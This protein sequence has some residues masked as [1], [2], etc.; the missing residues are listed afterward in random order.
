MSWYRGAITLP[1]DG[2]REFLAK[3]D[4][5]GMYDQI[6]RAERGSR[7]VEVEAGPLSRRA[8]DTISSC[9]ATT[10]ALR[11]MPFESIR[12]APPV[13][14]RHVRG[15]T[16]PDGASVAASEAVASVESAGA[17]RI[18]GAQVEPGNDTAP[19]AVE[20]PDD[21]PDPPP[22]LEILLPGIDLRSLEIP[23]ERSTRPTPDPKGVERA[24]L[25]IA[26]VESTGPDDYRLPALDAY[27]RAVFGYGLV[28]GMKKLQAKEPGIVERL[29]AQER[30]AQAAAAD[31][32]SA[33]R[34]GEPER[35]IT[36]TELRAAAAAQ[37]D[38][39]GSPGHPDG[40]A[41]PPSQTSVEAGT[42]NSVDTSKRRQARAKLL[43]LP[44]G[45]VSNRKRAAQSA[46]GK[47]GRGRHTTKGKEASSV[48]AAR[49]YQQ[50]DREVVPAGPFREDADEVKQYIRQTVIGYAPINWA[51]HHIAV[52]MARSM[53]SYRRG[54]IAETLS[55]TA[56]SSEYGGGPELQ[57]AT[58]AEVK[59]ATARAI[60]DWVQRARAA[61]DKSGRHDW[62]RIVEPT[63]E[64]DEAEAFVLLLRE[65]FGNLDAGDPTLPEY[66]P[67]TQRQWANLVKSYI[68]E[69]L[70]DEWEQVEIFAESKIRNLEN[71]AAA[72]RTKSRADR[73]LIDARNLEQNMPM[74]SK[75][76]DLQA[77]ITRKLNGLQAAFDKAQAAGPDADYPGPQNVE[78]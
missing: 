9:Q 10:Q 72:Y 4:P 50:S 77:R 37:L 19:A 75:V 40:T 15:A 3:Q 65:Y 66:R 74:I 52:Q 56:V 60:R 76:A 28:A 24:L 26:L 22:W 41:T 35:I 62:R 36:G 34:D 53:Q 1:G 8:A 47:K 6:L 20:V 25:E 48:N 61:I 11:D 23:G 64:R 59:A 43:R 12:P 67:T 44:P 18:E 63:F 54:D 21:K 33:R 78:Y 5:G 58:A 71:S 45:P 27:F 7:P 38:R 30:H 55:Y 57:M 14:N 29:R 69:F 39:R 73:M 68:H 42:S 17:D 46:N 31:G 70:D 49:H 2:L 51:A 32:D 16:R 13:G